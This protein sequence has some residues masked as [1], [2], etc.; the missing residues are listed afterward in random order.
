ME[1]IVKLTREV[2]TSAGVLLPRSWLNKEVVVTL[3]DLNEADIARGVFEILLERNL[4]MDV[5]GIYLIGS[6]ARGDYD[7]DS[8]IDILVITEKTNRLI[9]SG[10]YEIVLIGEDKLRMNLKDSLYSLSMIREAKTIMNQDL[11]VS[12]GKIKSGI[13]YGKLIKEIKG[14]TKVNKESVEVA[15][16]YGQNVSDGTAYS[17]VLRLR[18]LFLARCILKSKKYSSKSFL[19]MI[20]KNGLIGLYEGYRRG[21]KNV[22]GTDKAEVGDAKRLI[23]LI[24]SM[25]KEVE[26]NGKR[27]KN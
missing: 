6:Y 17:L 26:L 22:K 20:K 4:L 13:D 24:E 3:K 1:K 9:E 5:K 16:E 19:D 7:L 21:K 12:L 25:I 2:G 23:L 11:L 27:K 14:V 8:D 18:E 10:E 15:E